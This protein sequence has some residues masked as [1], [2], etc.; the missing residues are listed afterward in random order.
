MS[1][2]HQKIL[3]ILDDRELAS[4]EVRSLVGMRHFGDIIV[5]RRTL[6]EHFRASLPPW[7]QAQLV[8]VRTSEDVVNL[9]LLLENSREDT[10]ALFVAG[11][12][13]FA[14][15]KRLT[16]LIERLPYAEEDF[17]DRL[18]KPLLVFLHNAHALIE[19]WPSFE[20]A[21]MHI[22]EKAWQGSQ[23]LQ[24]VDLLDLAKIRDFLLFTSG[25]TAT[26]H[27]N[28]VEIDA[29]YYTKRS[30][31]KQK[32]QAEYAFY[33]L[34]PEPMRAWLIQPFDYRDEDSRASY[35]M[36]R[37]YLADA[38]LQWVHGAFEAE[39]FEPF[40]ER[41]LFFLAER[42]RRACSKESCAAIARELFVNKVQSR[43]EQFLAMDAGQ[44]IN[45]LATA[46]TPALD[47]RRQLERYLALYQR[48]QKGFAFDHLVV[49]HG[50]PCF[51]NVLYDQQRYLLKLIDPK[52]AVTEE[53]LWTHPL[54]DLCKVSHSALGD[55]DFINTGLYS[56]GFSDNN[57]L[58][59]RVQHSN[60]R[61]LQ[62]LFLQRIK[63]MGH[64]ARIMRLGEASLFLSMLPLHTDYPN[65]I[66]AFLL[67]ASQ[68]LDE[69][70]SE[71]RI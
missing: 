67:K 36:M 48:H 66:I 39:T 13:V 37:Y 20:L 50:D 8:H 44:R 57:D 70:E 68:I 31:D 12:A 46:A 45:K 6:L 55:Y 64:D 10:S 52:G 38:A 3:L 71:Q 53:A 65:K 60:H 30:T 19:Q 26:R 40:V 41:L 18:Y 62:P 23:R 47:I 11:S 4:G 27:F 25:S 9:R 29:Y 17:T 49:G 54:Y 2:L 32:M 51:S 43:V 59:L 42:P 35:R 24:S 5:K 61:A 22:W 33:G 56:V 14:D 58:L 16:Q 69:V 15:A 63:A 1:D 28:E 7:A 21:P 34:V